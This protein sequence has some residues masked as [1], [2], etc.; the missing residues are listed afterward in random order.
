MGLLSDKTV[1]VFTLG[2]IGRYGRPEILTKGDRLKTILFAG[3]TI[4]LKRVF[5]SREEP[6]AVNA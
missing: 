2:Q 3:L 4:D 1:M 6:A 5:S